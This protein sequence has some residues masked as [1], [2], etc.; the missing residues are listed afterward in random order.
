MKFVAVSALIFSS[1]VFATAQS[2]GAS[3]YISVVG[4]S[5]NVWTYD[6]HLSDTGATDLGTLW[7]AWNPG[8]NYLPDAP[9]SWSAPSGWSFVGVTHGDSGDG[10][11]MRWD[12]SSSGML[13]PGASLDGFE[14]STVDSPT[15]LDGFTT[16]PDYAG[17]GQLVG[18]SFVYAGAPFASASDNIIIQTVP[19]PTGIAGLSIGVFTLLLFKRRK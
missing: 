16:A 4:E 7:Y 2:I 15:V 10:Y 13:T 18:D 17:T 6:I 11:G 5:N 12:A 3:A 9:T 19:S 8:Q 14:F 1:I